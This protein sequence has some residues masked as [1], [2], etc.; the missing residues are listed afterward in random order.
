MSKDGG[1]AFPSPG[2]VVSEHVQASVYDV[3]T[4]RDRSGWRTF[5][6]GGGEGMTLRDWFAGQALAG[7]AGRSFFWPR[8]QAD[9]AYEVADAMLAA[10]ERPSESTGGEG[11]TE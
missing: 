3:G 7:G 1:P 2:Q 11:T 8:D 5:T 9:K 4:E 6:V 10:R